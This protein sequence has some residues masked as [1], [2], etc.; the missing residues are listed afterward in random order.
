MDTGQDG[1]TTGD[2]VVLEW[3]VLDVRDVSEM[4][5]C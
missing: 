1:T 2:W 3:V 4:S 5:A